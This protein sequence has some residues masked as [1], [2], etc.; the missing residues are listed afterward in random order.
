VAGYFIWK[1]LRK[2]FLVKILKRHL[3]F[4]LKQAVYFRANHLAQNPGVF[5][6]LRHGIACGRVPFQFHHTEISI[7]HQC[8]QVNRLA[9]PGFDLDSNQDG[10]QSQ[11]AEMLF[12]PFLKL[13]FELEWAGH[14]SGI[15][16]PGCARKKMLGS[17]FFRRWFWFGR[18]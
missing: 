6:R 11:L 2:R 4:R 3:G 9:I 13:R 17:V 5:N 1:R 16:A 15:F 8:Q 18:G 7:I 10:V 14:Q 12:E